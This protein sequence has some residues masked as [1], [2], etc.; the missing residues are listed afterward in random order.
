MR[1]NEPIRHHYIPQ[2]ILRNF[3]YDSFNH[4]NYY[5]V[6]TKTII[7]AD[8]KQVFMHKNLYRDEINYPNIP[9]NIETDLSKFESE[10]SKIIKKML[11][12]KDIEI[13][14]EDLDSIMVFLAIMGFRSFNVFT[15]FEKSKNT[16]LYKFWQKDGDFATFWKRNLSNLANCRSLQEV[17]NHDYI[18][19]PIKVFMM[20]DIFGL[21][22]KYIVLCEKR[23]NEEFCISDTYPLVINGVDDNNMQ[24]PIFEYFPLSPDRVLILVGNGVEGAPLSVRMLDDKFIKKPVQITKEKIKIHVQKIYEPDVIRINKEIIENAKVG[25]VFKNFN[26]VTALPLDE[27]KV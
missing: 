16:E 6:T 8:T 22:G 25:V 14:I 27:N 3:S 23:G 26:K 9:T 12:G 2:F 5:D 11:V 17:T 1:V 20:R 7:N 18:D 21:Y 24:L 19:E 10:V 15:S 13:S 4:L